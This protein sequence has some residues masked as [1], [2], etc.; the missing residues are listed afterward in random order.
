ML[1]CRLLGNSK[2]QFITVF[3]LFLSLNISAQSL[4]FYKN[5]I[6]TDTDSVLSLLKDSG[7]KVVEEIPNEDCLG[8]KLNNDKTTVLYNVCNYDDGTIITLNV[9]ESDLERV[10]NR[11]NDAN[12][13]VTM[14]SKISTVGANTSFVFE[15]DSLEMFFV[16][17]HFDNIHY[18]EISNANRY[19]SIKK[20]LESSS[21]FNSETNGISLLRKILNETNSKGE[22]LE[23][24]LKDS[25]IKSNFNIFNYEEA[26]NY[27]EDL[28]NLEQY[29]DLKNLVNNN[30]LS[31]EFYVKNIKAS[32]LK[33][34]KWLQIENNYNERFEEGLFKIAIENNQFNSLVMFKYIIDSI[35][36]K[37]EN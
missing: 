28:R 2:I 8:Y 35:K 23:Q 7:Y 18:M 22:S 32:F 9:I 10:Y 21:D 31:D 37:K 17:N 27:I 20:L 36:N 14:K 1:N 25:D 34:T 5:L 11:F 33:F 12:S 30:L 3:I 19:E 15:N 16:F 26:T 4:D 13:D 6:S 29:T 24:V